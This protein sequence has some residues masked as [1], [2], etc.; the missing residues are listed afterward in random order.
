MSK[1]DMSNSKNYLV[2]DIAKMDK[3]VELKIR[4]DAGALLPVYKNVGDAGA[5][6]HS[7]EE[8]VIP[9]MERRI[10]KTGL[11]F[12][13]PFGYEVQIRSRSGLAAK[14]GIFVLNSPGT[15]DSSYRGEIKV[16]L[17]NF[18]DEAF[19]IN[20]GD[21]VAQMVIAPVCYMPFVTVDSLEI[22]DRGVG[23]FGSTGV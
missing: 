10:V 4:V 6:L 3:R 7:L 14:D 16:I 11:Y 20:K 17:Q 1:K 15:I 12:E 13:I 21:R 2:D 23:G 18:S 22:S 19:V 9:P 8:L 5:D